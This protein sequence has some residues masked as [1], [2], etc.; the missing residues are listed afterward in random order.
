MTSYDISKQ[1]IISLGYKWLSPSKTSISILNIKIP[2]VLTHFTTFDTMG[3]QLEEY[4]SLKLWTLR[5]TRTIPEM[6]CIKNDAR[7]FSLYF[8]TH[9]FRPTNIKIPS[10]CS[11]R[12][13]GKCNT[14][15]RADYSHIIA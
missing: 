15:S 10:F 5:F 3:T 4:S 1:N 12:T 8:L 2:P 6:P 9:S 11:S 14:P 7:H 13:T